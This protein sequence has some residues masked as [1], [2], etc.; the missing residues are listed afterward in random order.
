[1][2]PRRYLGDVPVD[3]EQPEGVLG[4]HQAVAQHEEVGRVWAEA[5][6]AD[7]AREDRDGDGG[8]EHPKSADLEVELGVVG[9]ERH[10][11]RE[12]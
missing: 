6:V 1:M 2:R 3:Q 11:G 8:G 4:E 10:V 5:V 7:P 9:E 12:P